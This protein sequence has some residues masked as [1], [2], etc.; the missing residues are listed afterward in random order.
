MIKTNKNTKIIIARTVFISN[1]KDKKLHILL[2]FNKIFAGYKFLL[3]ITN[4]IE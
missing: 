2:L 4:Y 1:N 3:K